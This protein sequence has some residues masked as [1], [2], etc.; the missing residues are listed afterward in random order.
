MKTVT[1]S[2]NAVAVLRFRVRGWPWKVNDRN[3]AAF[4]ELVVAGIME[5]DGQDY[6]FPPEDGSG[7][8]RS[9][10]ARRSG[11]WRWSRRCRNGLI[12]RRRP[13]RRSPD[14][15]RATAR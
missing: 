1:L 5:P 8:R 4:E 10:A 2:E 11:S 3:R 9:S 7:A 12:S 15:W 14:T 6:R 13:G